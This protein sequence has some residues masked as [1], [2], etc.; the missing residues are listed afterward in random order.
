MNPILRNV[1]AVVA[2][3]IVGGVINMG[4]IYL[5]PVII[6]PPEGADMTTM[7][8]IK[9]AMPQMETKHFIMPFVAHA[10]GTLSGAYTA[11]RL[12]YSNHF[13]LAVGIGFFFLVGG[14]MAAIQL[15]SPLWFEVFDIVVAYLPMGWL[16]WKMTVRE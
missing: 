1:L 5:G 12:A 6:P 7:E 16:G 3:I 14:V 15:P 11:A 8:G 13:R 10:I 9:A 4:L 2:G